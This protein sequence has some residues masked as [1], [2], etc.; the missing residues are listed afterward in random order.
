MSLRTKQV[1]DFANFRLD[2]SEKV[3]LRDGRPVPLTPK[4]F[5][6]LLILIKNAGRLVEKEELMQQL[7]QDSFVEESNLTFN[8]GVLRK[9]LGDKVVKPKFIETVRGRG[10]R[11]IAD[12][13]YSEID[14]ENLVRSGETPAPDVSDLSGA[15]ENPV[16][17]NLLAQPSP[18]IGRETELEEINRLLGQS[19]IRLMTVTGVGGTGKTRLSQAIAYNSLAQFTDGVF[20]IDLSAIENAELVIP[21]I[22]ET[23]GIRE[24]SR[25]PLIET[26]RENL[27]E[28]KMLVILDNFEQIRRAASRIGELI[29]YSRN[30]K[31]LVTS[32]VRLFLTF[33]YEFPLQPLA[34]P[35]DIKVSREEL[36]E[37]PAVALFIARARTVKPFF[38]LTEENA[39]SIVEIC[40]RL[41]GLPLA[42]ELAAVRVK[43]FA[44]QAILTR[45]SSSLKLLTGGSHV[46]PARQRTMR[47]TIAWSYDLLGEEEK[48]MFNR[49][50]VFTG[51]FTLD[52]A[53]AVVHAGEDFSVE[54]L[55]LATSLTDQSLLSQRELPN[56]EPRFRMLTVVREYALEILEASSEANEIKRRH[57][58]FYAALAE[59][60]EPKLLS[61]SGSRW[62]QILEEEHDNL[63]S[64]IEWS[65]ENDPEIA[66]RIVGALRNFWFVRGY[67][68]EGVK[69]IKRAL[70]KKETEANPGL[71]AKALYS[72]G[73]LH[74][75]QGEFE[76]AKP[77]LE[78][79][80]RVAS[81]AAD[82]NLTSLSLWALGMIELEQGDLN[83]AQVL[84]EE[85]LAIAR[86][87]ND[88]QHISLRLTGLGEIARAQYNYETARRHYE[89]AL[90]L[91]R[92]ESSKYYIA[93]HTSNLA[94]TTCLL[95]DYRAAFAYTLECLDVT[96]DLGDKRNMGI[97]LSIFGALAV[98]AGKIEKAARLWGAAQG[99]FDS[100]NFKPVKV[101][102]DF[103]EQYINEARAAIGDE[104]FDVAFASGR[105]LP[106]KEAMMLA[107][108]LEL[109]EKSPS[110]VVKPAKPAITHSS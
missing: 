60:A 35:T 8:L 30:L 19:D 86:E 73:N 44:P 3:L 92:E 33:E 81:A 14:D 84:I 96:E 72:I 17:N 29:S 79:G 76:T 55:D 2:F 56:G 48:K 54:L 38:E 82:K 77:Y 7:W 58:R 80:L 90:S 88:K 49:L 91:A 69:W 25:K 104:A 62:L 42:I 36:G 109:P 107:R 57:A 66:L 43:L 95:G 71:L 47:G 83:E 16:P 87:M 26:M 105:T 24:D 41:D 10:Y 53:E 5:D 110:F 102:R 13:R 94:Y 108:Q 6:T 78:E 99:I 67:L 12:V 34:V 97:T 106:L 52:A 21:I 28:K 11:F 75:F 40:R 51:G 37:Y 32:R 93:I 59:A 18:L 31:I 20:F 50:A 68:S 85:S 101:D 45:L 65:L 63:R 98:A 89:E 74:R 27:Q 23:L 100:I 39:P 46:S 1:Y 9:A 64:A 22:A 70:D 61:A 15:S 103:K 4:V